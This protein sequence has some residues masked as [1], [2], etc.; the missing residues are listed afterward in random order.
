MDAH[1]FDLILIY[2]QLQFDQFRCNFNLLLKIRSE[3]I[4]MI[5]AKTE[6]VDIYQKSQLNFTFLIYLKQF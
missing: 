2:V 5:D 6:N 3:M 1:D 4:K